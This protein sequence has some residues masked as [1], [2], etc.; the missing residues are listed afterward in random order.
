MQ[1][2]G[3]MALTLCMRRLGQG[4]FPAQVIPIIHIESQRDKI[5]TGGQFAQKAVRRRTGV[6]A[7][8]G[9]KL[10]HHLATCFRHGTLMDREERYAEGK[11]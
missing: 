11:K 9:V 7:L 2:G 3:V 10:H 4:V 6:A 8:G 5:I 1:G